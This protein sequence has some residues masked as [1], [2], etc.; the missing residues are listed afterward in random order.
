MPTWGRSRA[1]RVAV[2][3]G[4]VA[5]IAAGLGEAGGVRVNVSPSLRLGVYRVA[6]APVV[7][8]A[9]VLLCLPAAVASIARARGYLWR[10]ACVGGVAPV[11]KVVVATAGDTVDVTTRGVWV[12]GRLLARSA[13]F[14][15]DT[16]GRPLMPALGRW[17]L[18]RGELWTYGDADPRSFDSRYFGPVNA[19]DV[20]AV[21]VS[22]F[23]RGRASGATFGKEGG[24]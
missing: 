1:S 3:V 15:V 19:D 22:V 11:G 24:G 5:A 12:N 9:T 16:R 10:G 8:G 6:H 14:S 17:V 13:P 18:V 23:A 2:G 4:C 20:R 21:I 7:R